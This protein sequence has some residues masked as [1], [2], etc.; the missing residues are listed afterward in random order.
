M[1]PTWLLCYYNNLYLSL[2]PHVFVVSIFYSSFTVEILFTFLNHSLMDDCILLYT[3]LPSVKIHILLLLYSVFG[4]VSCRL[5]TNSMVVP[6]VKRYQEA[7]QPKLI[8]SGFLR[9]MY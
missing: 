9:K 5:E 3:Y 4:F 8:D 7:R 6:R 1:I 2:V